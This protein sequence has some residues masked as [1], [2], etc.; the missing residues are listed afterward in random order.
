MFSVTPSSHLRHPKGQ[1]HSQATELL[2]HLFFTK[3]HRA[4]IPSL[5]LSLDGRQAAWA[6]VTSCSAM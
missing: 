4:V 2:S 3:D 6:V 5:H 1:C